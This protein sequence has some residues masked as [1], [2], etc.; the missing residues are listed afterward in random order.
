MRIS[1]D[2]VTTLVVSGL[3]IGS[4]YAVLL[5]LAFRYLGRRGGA[6]VVILALVGWSA[7]LVTDASGRFQGTGWSLR[8]AMVVLLIALSAFPA[9]AV[10]RA[11]R[12]S[13]GSYARQAVYGLG[14][15]ILA[16]LG[17]L[18][19]GVPILLAGKRSGW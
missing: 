2:A 6:L 16:I 14:G 3:A 19:V 11:R 10:D 13:V 5:V 17:S 1:T 8:L 9:L 12:Q 4:L 7:V 15:F 18:V